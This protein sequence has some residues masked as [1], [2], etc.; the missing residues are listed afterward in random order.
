MTDFPVELDDWDGGDRPRQL[1][2]RTLDDTMSLFGSLLGSLALVWLLY[3]RILPVQGVLG[4]VLT[5]YLL[6]LAMYAAVSAAANPWP[7]I[8][9]RIAAAIMH[10]GAA[11]VG[12]AL[13]STLVYTYVRAAPALIH[14]N[15]YTQDMAGVRPTAPLNQ[16]GVLHAI[17]GSLIEVGL[18]VVVALPLG[19][20]VAVFMTEVGGRL[21]RVLRTVMEAMTAL[22]D[23]LAGLFIY[24]VLIL[25]LGV[26]RSGIAAACA[27][28]VMMTPII[29]RSSDVVLRVVPG[30]LREASL[31]LGSS[32]W[33]AVW[34][35]V[36]PTARPGLATA[37]ILGMARTFG[38]TAPVLITSGA[39]TYFNADPLHHSMNSLPLY[40]LTAV[41]SGEPIFIQRG[42][43][44][45]GILLAIVLLLFIGARR[46][47]R[48]RSTR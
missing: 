20:G 35:V 32:Q 27:L 39:S 34:H 22:P 41:R 21:G 33:R 48:Q 18:A 4:F 42:F 47:A 7:V 17:V 1:S 6:F 28:A 25:G 5:W 45:A 37:L 13:L 26:E 8:A 16:G 29:A 38:E 31:A 43:A 40:A 36:L 30:G 24:T 46:L 2:Q 10:G 15:T 11:V 9:D 14:L 12:I 19:V 3:E 23:I 44:A